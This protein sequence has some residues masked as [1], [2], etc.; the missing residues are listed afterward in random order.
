MYLDQADLATRQ[1]FPEIRLPSHHLPRREDSHGSDQFLP[2]W[3]FILVDG[4]DLL[5]ARQVFQ[6]VEASFSWL[7]FL[8]PAFA[9]LYS[10]READR[11]GWDGARAHG[12]GIKGRIIRVPSAVRDLVPQ[13]TYHM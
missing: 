12:T 11:T 2:A 13:E 1:V 8:R 6:Q 3:K 5:G 9:G 4:R 10:F 7:P